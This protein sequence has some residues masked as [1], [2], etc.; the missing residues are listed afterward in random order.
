MT[1]K[2]IYDDFLDSLFISSKKEKDKVQGSAKLGDLVFDF[3]NE[4][5]IVNVEIRHFSAFFKKLTNKKPPNIKDASL[6]VDCKRDSVVIWITVRFKNK[7][8]QKIPVYI[9][10]QIAPKIAAA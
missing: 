1:Q 2:F 9:S 10:T 5:K 7:E 6:T 3:T 8:E 4:G